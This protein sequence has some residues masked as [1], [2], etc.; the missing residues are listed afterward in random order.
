M[1]RIYLLPDGSERIPTPEERSHH[2]IALSELGSDWSGDTEDAYEA[3]WKRGWVRVVER[4]DQVY[5]EMWLDGQPVPLANLTS[6]Q[7]LWLEDKI[8]HGKE[9]IWNSGVFRITREDEKH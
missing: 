9:I 3:M 1:K 5:A 7:Q 4:Q 2:G 6:A 8:E